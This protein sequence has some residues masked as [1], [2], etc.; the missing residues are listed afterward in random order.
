MF[1]YIYVFICMYICIY[2]YISIHEQY[3]FQSTKGSEKC[4][5]SSLLSRL[6][7]EKRVQYWTG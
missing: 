7:N 4:H 5:Q 3:I 2:M 1:M 6:I